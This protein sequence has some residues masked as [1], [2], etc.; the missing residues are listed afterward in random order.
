MIKRWQKLLNFIN[1]LIDLCLIMFSYIAAVYLWL[2]VIRKD[3]GNIA[4]AFSQSFWFALGLS[5]ITVFLYQ[6]V[7]LY[8]SIRAKPIGHNVKRV[9]VLNTIVS[10]TG[11]ALLYVFRL[12][13][14]SRGVIVFFYIL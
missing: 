12:E 8:D 6:L 13:D 3:T 5:F 9:L 11:A 10:L 7:G 1:R 14:F 4:L 2:I